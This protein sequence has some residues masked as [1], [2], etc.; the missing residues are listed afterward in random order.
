MLNCRSSR[1][2][3]ERPILD[4][5]HWIEL[6]YQLPDFGQAAEIPAVDP[7]DSV[8]AEMERRRGFWNVVRNRDQFL[9]VAEN[10]DVKGIVQIESPKGRK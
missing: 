9:I 2:T 4:V 3:H 7:R 6:H 5:R 1:L 8:R 10:R